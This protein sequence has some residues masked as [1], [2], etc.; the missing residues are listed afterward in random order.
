[1]IDPVFCPACGSRRLLRQPSENAYCCLDC[2]VVHYLNSKAAVCAIIV[3][4][5]SV[6]LVQGHD[7][8]RGW[9][10]PGGFLRLGESPEDGLE[11]ELQEELTAHV[12]VVQLLSAKV[13]PYG[14]QGEFSLN[15]FYEATL[16]TEELVPAN[17]I[18]QFGWFSLLQ[19]PPL[20]YRGTAWALEDFA[21]RTRV[22]E[23]GFRSRP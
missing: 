3:R 21:H 15:L 18:A 2:N 20:E 5:G 12:A 7:S 22:H 9:D 23:Q 17:E 6:L 11:R 4:D 16:L 13:D 19:L 8:A 1:M 14:T 10:L